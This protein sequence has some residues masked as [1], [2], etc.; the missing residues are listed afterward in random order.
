MI[1]DV[2]KCSKCKEIKNISEFYKCISNKDGYR[3]QCIICT[4]QSYIYNKDS[5]SKRAKE[6]Y[7]NNKDIIIEKSK[8]YYKNNKISVSKTAKTRRKNN[9]VIIK[10]QKRLYYST[11]KDIINKKSKIYRTSF[12]SYE[13][14][15]HQLTVEEEPRLA[16]DGM[17]LEAR[18]KYCGKYFKPTNTQV[19]GRTKALNV[20]NRG[21]LHLYCSDDCRSNCDIYGQHINPKGYKINK[22]SREVQPALRKLVLERD[23]W[24]CQKC[25]S[26]KE[27]HCHHFEGIE[28]NPIES[29][30]IDNC[31]TLCKKC[32]KEVHKQDYCNM[33]REKCISV[34]K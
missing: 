22:Y 3:Y 7:K 33:K 34:I 8:K 23:N 20:E 11:N 24:I 21:E 14:Y 1:S 28:I 13:T 26:S 27:L 31:V 19:Q 17:S 12:A 9:S 18:C 30:D 2:K 4:K 15:A 25:D 32:H 29:A 5:I 16:D 10:K 6:Y